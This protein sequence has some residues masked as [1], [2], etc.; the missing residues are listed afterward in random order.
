[1][2]YRRDRVWIILF[3][4]SNI[5]LKKIDLEV[6]KKIQE[7]AWRPNFKKSH[8]IAW[9]AHDF[10]VDFQLGGNPLPPGAYLYRIFINK[11][12]TLYYYKIGGL[13]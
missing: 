5:F 3:A 8:K 11:A 4:P 12:A 13:F 1:M 9:L 2:F 7:K 10:L 6:E